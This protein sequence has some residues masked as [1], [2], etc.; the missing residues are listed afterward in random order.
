VR[1]ESNA[2]NVASTRNSMGVEAAAS[3]GVIAKVAGNVI[4]CA[5]A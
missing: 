2:L 1:P 3:P 4:D 5:A